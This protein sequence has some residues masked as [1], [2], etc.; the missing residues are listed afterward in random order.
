MIVLVH[1]LMLTYVVDALCID[2]AICR[3]CKDAMTA[4]L[5]SLSAYLSV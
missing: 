1:Y 5:E 2:K 4:Q 3:S